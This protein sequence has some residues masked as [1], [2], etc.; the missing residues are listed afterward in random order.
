MSIVEILKLKLSMPDEIIGLYKKIGNKAD[1]IL[2]T[3]TEKTEE[4]DALNT[5][6]LLQEFI[7]KFPKTL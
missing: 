3:K 2:H 6:K 1:N 7:E 5:I 4:E